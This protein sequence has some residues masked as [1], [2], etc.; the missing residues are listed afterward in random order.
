MANSPV[1]DLGDPF[2]YEIMVGGKNVAT[3]FAIMHVEVNKEINQIPTATITIADGIP[4]QTDFPVSAGKE[5]LP[6][7]EVEVKLGYESKNTSVYK[8]VIMKHMITSD[9]NGS[10][11][12]V[13]CK[14]KLTKMTIGRKNAF[15]A[16]KK[17][18][19]IISSLVSD[20]G[21][22]ATVKATTYQH[23]NMMQFNATD[24]DFM[25]MRADANGM[26][27]NVD[28]GKATVE[29]P[30]TS[31]SPEIKASFADGSIFDFEVEMNAEDQLEKASGYAWADGDQKLVDG[32]GKASL[33]MPGDVTPKKLAGVLGVS[34]FNMQSVGNMES[35]D[36]KSWAS[37][38]LT[39]AQL[40]SFTG[41]VT[42]VGSSK[43]VPGGML[44]LAGMG[45]HF[46]GNAFIRGV[47]HIVD[48][49]WKTEVLLGMPADWY[50]ESKP[51][52]AAPPAGGLLPPVAGLQIGV[53]KSI[54]KDPDNNF[55]VEVKVPIMQQDK[56][57]VW[58][59]LSTFYATNKSG[60]FFYPE[61]NDEVVLGFLN[62]DPRYPII[63]GSVH[64]SKLPPGE[65]P[66]KKNETKAFISKE[67]IKITF[68]E[69]DK[70]L[71]LETPGGNSLAISDKDKGLALED[72]NGNKIVMDNSGIEINS[73][74]KLVLKSAQD[75]EITSSAKLTEKGTSGVSV[76][77]MKI[78]QKADTTFSAQGSA[79]AELK[80]SGNVTV[81]GAMVM[82]N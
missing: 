30:D 27:V 14:D 65:T 72:Q 77:G 23:K 71:T 1:E 68:D 8:G 56:D 31:V 50:H 13:E 78:E 70:V 55:R 2:T 32:A 60:A 48:D 38:K 12:V 28:G 52:V 5:F 22:S 62:D 66:E 7:A 40:A 46:N 16:K 3:A 61:V 24:W 49:K 63:L 76:S 74:K 80:A 4:S 15:F 29:P 33:K 37:A 47:N 10:S 26:L 9:D 64:S 39:R 53:V 51:N 11:L 82:I 18:S 75:T 58:A 43:V 35:A 67:K 44:E 69:K 36:L 34:E 41:R 45:T 54:E 79:S 21:G 73:A 20:G 57:T 19:D 81:K 42:I 25:L 17:D 59:R 6:G